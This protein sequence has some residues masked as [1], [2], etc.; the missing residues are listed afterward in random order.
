M[1]GKLMQRV[2]ALALFED[3]MV[4]VARNEFVRRVVADAI[5]L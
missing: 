5:L 4:A 1:C 2:N 3:T